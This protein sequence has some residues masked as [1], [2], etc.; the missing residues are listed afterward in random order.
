MPRTSEQNEIIRLERT[1]RIEMSALYLFASKGFDGTTLDEIARESKSSHGL[2][3]HYFKNKEKLYEYIL[4]EVA[5]PMILEIVESVNRNQKAKDVLYDT[6]LAFLKA[7]KS[8]NDEYCWAINVLLSVDLSI[9][10]GTKTKYITKANNKNVFMWVFDLVEK[11]KEEGDFS[12][13]KDTKQVT[14]STL[15]VFKGLA[16]SRMRLGQKKFICPTADILMDL[17]K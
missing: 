1:R 2:L 13:K 17:A 12:R 14:A 7:L 8:E 16:Y 3:Y 11:G 15:S 10:A 5:I 4:N 6:H 9:I